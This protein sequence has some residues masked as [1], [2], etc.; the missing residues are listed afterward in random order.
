MLTMPNTSRQMHPNSV[1]EWRRRGPSLFDDDE[2]KLQYLTMIANRDDTL[3]LTLAGWDD[4]LGGIAK[5]TRQARYRE[6]PD[7][8][9]RKKMS[10]AEYSK[11]RVSGGRSAEPDG[12][13]STKEN[14]RLTNA[15]GYND[16][17]P[18]A[19]PTVGQEGYRLLCTGF[20][21]QLLLI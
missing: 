2:A 4:G 14:E 20:I 10:F 6:G 11:K 1:T 19:S 5:E 13:R 16:D 12:A 18:M 17:E 7:R 21:M 15:T 3:L 8:Q 9:A